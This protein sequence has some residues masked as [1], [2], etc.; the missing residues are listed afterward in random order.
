MEEQ[1]TSGKQ[2]EQEDV[3]A[4]IRARALNEDAESSD[5][6]GRRARSDDDDDDVQ[7]HIRKA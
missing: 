4:H 5:E 2:E 7:A 6:H 3:Q 1:E